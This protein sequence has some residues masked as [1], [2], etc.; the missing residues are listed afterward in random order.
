MSQPGLFDDLGA[1]RAAPHQLLLASA[2]TGKTFRL[3]NHFAGLLLGGVDPRRVLA[4]TF[5]RKAAGEIQGRVLARLAE[6]VREDADGAAARAMLLEATQRFDP[7]RKGVTAEDCRATLTGLVRRIE[8]L[9]V[10]TLDAFFVRL[11]QL[12]AMEL[13]IA[14]EWRVADEVEEARL[15]AEGVARVVE[16][17][18][19]AERLELLRAIAR[20]GAS[21]KAQSALQAAVEEGDEIARDAEDGAWGRLEPLD[22]VDDAAV[23]RAAAFL[24]AFDVPK[25]KGGEPKKHWKNAIDGLLAIVGDGTGPIPIDVVDSGLVKKV[26]ANEATY[27]SVEIDEGLA[28]AIGAIVA[29][30]S[31][32][33]I[34]DVRARNAATAVFL[35]RYADADARL[36][37]ESGAYRF[38][39]FPRALEDGPARTGRDEW[40]TE[41]G[42]R[43]DARLDH[44]LLDEFQDTS[45]SQWRLLLPLASEVLSDGTGERSFFCVG[46]VKQSI[47][48]WRGGE[49][50]LLGRMARRHPVLQPEELTKSYRSSPIVLDLVNRAFAGLA[51]RRCFARAGNEAARDAA[52]E[53]AEGFAPHASAREDLGGEARIWQ[54]RPFS[55]SA[56]ESEL[57]PAIRFAVERV[58][59][60]AA[61]RPNASIA[62]LVRNRK[63][64]PRLRFLLGREGIEASDEGGN[65]LTDSLG[66][67]WVIG[68]LHLADHPLDGVAALQVAR[69]PF[70]ERYGLAPDEM[71]TP[72]GRV[73]AVLAART[74]RARLSEV[75]YGAFCE[76]HAAELAEGASAWDARRLEQLVD[77]ALA[78]DARAGLRPIDFVDLV[79][80]LRVP[81]PARARVQVMTIHASKGLEFDVVVLPE[82]GRRIDISVDGIAVD[83]ESEVDRPR[84]ATTV[85]K[86]AIAQQHPTLARLVADEQRRITTDALSSLYVA[87]TRA[88]H[89]LELILTGPPKSNVALSPASIVGEAFGADLVGAW[90]HEEDAV[91]VWEDARSNATWAERERDEDPAPPFAERALVLRAGR[92]GRESVEV[93]APSAK[94]AG[95]A[96]SAEALLASTAG[97]AARLGTLV[98]ALFEDFTW[99][100]D[101]TRTDEQLVRAAERL[102]PETPM[103]AREAASRFRTALASPGLAELFSKPPGDA[104]V[105]TERTFDVDGGEGF[106]WRGTIDRV[107]LH[108]QD[109]RVVRADVIDFKTDAAEREADVVEAHAEQIEVYRDAI[110]ALYGL[111]HD[112]IRCAIAWLGGPDGGRTIWL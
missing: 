9:Q 39:D 64:I 30:A 54:V 15:V 41:L 77:L 90:P 57:E 48:G 99:T 108:L 82:L 89:G 58:T 25:T 13:A 43:L 79:R 110:G 106:R 28:R 53:W 60:L 21:R 78:H 62:I 37:A 59:E 61:E 10:R 18:G 86:S 31:Q 107:V 111:D 93:R 98:H 46:D 19:D 56:G 36:R 101:E 51:D 71:G 2:G 84:L 8:R 50:R 47:Y 52:V 81:D 69:S 70:G 24:A 3:A 88:I 97:D 87:L 103:L 42:F 7:T 72:P 104:D 102:A 23:Q 45:P 92:S 63:E 91:L 85:P 73:A 38:S 34:E 75:G 94:A 16:D 17:L 26:L 55:R 65:A 22:G 14:P 95:T 83:R 1:E 66:V 5:T 35:G 96:R 112:A 11:A 6:G 67:R 29:R 76:E 49:P 105:A 109:E 44:L 100:E 68:L 33:A 80:T 12:F 32:G 20:G 40:T 74:V 27:D 4:T